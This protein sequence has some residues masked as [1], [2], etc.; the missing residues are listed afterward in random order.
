MRRHTF[1]RQLG[2]GVLVVASALVACASGAA[3]SQAPYPDRPIHIVVPYGTGGGIDQ[4]ARIIG[5]ALSSALGQPVIVE[6]RPGADSAIGATYVARAKGDGYT[7][8]F[9]SQAT[10]AVLPLLNAQLQYDPLRDF[11]AVGKVAKLPFFAV[12][13]SQLPITNISELIAYARAKPSELSYASG[14]NGTP[15]HLGMELL[16]SAAG[17]DITHVPYKGMAAAM[18][19]LMTGRIAI[20]MT[21]LLVAGGALKK[22]SARII[23]VSTRARS[24]L[25]PDMATLAEQGVADFDVEVWLGLFAPAATPQNAIARVNSAL[26]RFLRAGETAESFAKFN[27]DVDPSTPEELGTLVRKETEKWGRVIRQAGIKSN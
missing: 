18:P 20:L 10:V 15:S 13:H 6:N 14:G 9:T 23:G 26:Q 11:A 19:D 12:V 2:T 7:F 1:D 16:K 5:N 3:H 4:S 17:I 21:D 27:F 22:G 25:M 24:K 8:L